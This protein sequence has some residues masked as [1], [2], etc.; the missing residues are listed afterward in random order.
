M[1]GSTIAMMTLVLVTGCSTGEDGRPTASETLTSTMPQT[2]GAGTETSS[3]PT[4]SGASTT[5]ASTTGDGTTGAVNGTTGESAGTSTG[6]EGGEP[7][8]DVGM[9]SEEPVCA[10]EDTCC[11]Q[12]GF[13]PPHKLLETFLAAYPAANMPK[14]DEELVKFEPVA[15]G[16]VMAY[17]MENVGNEFI[18][19]DQGGVIE[20]NIIKGRMF[21]RMKAEAEIP[22]GAAVLEVREDPIVIEKLGDS[23]KGCIGVGWG[24]GS[25]IFEAPDKSIGELVYLYVGHCYEGDAEAFFYSEQAVELCPAPG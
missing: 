11:Q 22:V 21:S 25:I 8:L 6:S 15:D 16:H 2:T 13:V 10:P 20:E 7:K 9:D 3:T 14:S 12:E 17:S 5:G 19:P 4:T 1:R 23:D 18:D 24:W